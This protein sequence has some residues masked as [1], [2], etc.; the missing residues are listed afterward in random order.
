MLQLKSFACAKKTLS[1][2]PG[3]KKEGDLKHPKT[4]RDWAKWQLALRISARLRSSLN[5]LDQKRSSRESTS[6]T[7][8]LFDTTA[9]AFMSVNSGW[10][11][12]PVAIVVCMGQAIGFRFKCSTVESGESRLVAVKGCLES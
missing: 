12:E 5:A 9:A 3:P 4:E 6:L 2:K 7:Q 11:A 10:T 1:I 8:I